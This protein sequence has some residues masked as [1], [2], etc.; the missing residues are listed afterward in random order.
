MNSPARAR[1]GNQ[2]SAAGMTLAIGVTIAFIAHEGTI[3][4]AGWTVLVLGT[5][6]GTG[7]GLYGARI[8][9]M[10]DMPQLVSIFNAVGGGGAALVALAE[11]ARASQAHGELNTRATVATFLDV[12][13]GAITFTGSVVA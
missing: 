11:F 9:Q 3:T 7:A 1:R 10:T 4:G 5:L 2:L 8:V 12:A 13:I 6:L